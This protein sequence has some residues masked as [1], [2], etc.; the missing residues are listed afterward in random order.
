MSSEEIAVWGGG[1]GGVY[2]LCVSPNRVLSLLWNPVVL[3]KIQPSLANGFSIAMNII[4]NFSKL[5]APFRRCHGY[6]C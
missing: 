2:T 5:C 3:I 4:R 6:N 1:G